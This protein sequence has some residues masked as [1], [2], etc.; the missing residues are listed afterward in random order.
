MRGAGGTG[1]LVDRR[2]HHTPTAG[3]RTRMQSP[4]FSK[5]IDSKFPGALVGRVGARTQ[6]EME[7]WGMG[8]KIGWAGG[9]SVA[10]CSSARWCVARHQRS[11]R[12]KMGGAGLRRGRLLW[13]HLGAGGLGTLGAIVVSVQRRGRGKMGGA[14]LRR[15]R[16]L[17][18]H[19]GA[20]GLGTLGAIVVSVH[21]CCP[22]FAL[23]PPVLRRL[24]V[25]MRS[26]HGVVTEKRVMTQ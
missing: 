24:A 6:V 18:S 3:Y 15:G 11:G 1:S 2:H 16:L 17:W 8:G 7:K 22:Q 9:G 21:P 14:G 5:L 4:G 26:V 10:A 13:S 19:L 12:G 20:G 23:Q 25:L